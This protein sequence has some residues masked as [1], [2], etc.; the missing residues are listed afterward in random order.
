MPDHYAFKTP[1]WLIFFQATDAAVTVLS[2]HR[3]DI[4]EKFHGTGAGAS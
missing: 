3:S 2:V 4:L 1:D